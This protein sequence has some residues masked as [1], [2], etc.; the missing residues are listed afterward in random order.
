MDISVFFD[1]GIRR[2]NNEDNYLI[3]DNS[4]EYTLIAVAD[5]MGGH[6]AGEVASKTA[7]DC[8]GQFNFNIN[9]DLLEE[10]EQ[11]IY[12]ANRKII[13]MSNKNIKYKGMGT[14][15]S[16]GI[17][18][19]D[20]LYYGHIGDSR[21]LYYRN[22]TLKQLTT[23]H[24]LVNKLIKEDKLNQEEAFNHPQRH[25]LTRALGLEFDIKI[26]TDVFELKR[27]DILLFCTDGLTDMI[28]LKN[29]EDIIK[30]NFSEIDI[31]TNNL[32]EKALANG[33]KDNLTLVTGIIN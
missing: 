12:Q 15:L 33:G 29:I 26:E 24:T 16:L 13:E 23:D 17:I 8:V 9:L 5:G 14:T 6:Q 27:N 1:K 11:V 30:N 18:Y 3:S 28:P 22:Q 4:R 25:I 2:S 7:I 20:K 32:G 19:N 31:I 10:I 21:I